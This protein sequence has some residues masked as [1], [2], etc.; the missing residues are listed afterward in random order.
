L[1]RERLAGAVLF[2]DSSADGLDRDRAVDDRVE[3]RNT[4]RPWHPIPEI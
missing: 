3:A 4:P 1:K 2:L